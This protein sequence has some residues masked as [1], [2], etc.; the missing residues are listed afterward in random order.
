MNIYEALRASHTLQREL[1]DALIETKGASEERTE[2]FTKLKH[3][4]EA[5]AVG[6]E[7]YFYVP[8]MM[9]DMTM[10]HARHGIAEHHTLDDVIETLETTELNAP[11]WLI[12][13]RKLRDE[14]YHH[15][16]EEEKTIF[17]ISGKV[18]TDEQKANLAGDYQA[19]YERFMA[20]LV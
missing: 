17:Q 14:V 12:N 6:E 4:L 9:H 7:R 18:L 11:S 2:L 5:H 13:A 1:A 8:L 10:P 16:E 19:E 3:E 20:K 15:L